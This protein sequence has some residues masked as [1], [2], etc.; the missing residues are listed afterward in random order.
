MRKRPR[1]GSGL[2]WIIREHGV[3]CSILII[4][5]KQGNYR[6]KHVARAFHA[7]LCRRQTGEDNLPRPSLPSITNHSSI[8]QLPCRQ[9]LVR[10]SVATCGMLPNMTR[11]HSCK[12]LGL[13]D[14]FLSHVCAFSTQYFAH[15]CM[16]SDQN[17]DYQ[18]QRQKKCS[19]K[20]FTT[21]LRI[22]STTDMRSAAAI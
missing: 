6:K 19:V 3:R 11:G 22:F 21:A 16:L 8:T 5:D 9:G 10:V 1:H 15:F 14:C 12:Y 13:C 20:N 7:Q 2:H 17:S 18:N 4:F